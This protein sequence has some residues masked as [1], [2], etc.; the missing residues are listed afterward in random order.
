MAGPRSRGVGRGETV[1]VGGLGVGW[2]SL[3]LR[4]LGPLAVN[5]VRR[6]VNSESSGGVEV[7]GVGSK[8][9][10]AP[11]PSSSMVMVAEEGL[12]LVVPTPVVSP[13][14]PPPRSAAT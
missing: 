2:K 6:V 10:P 12:E 5:L 7:P 4:E 3:P 1:P 9:Q 14:P 11:P 8:Y 13:R